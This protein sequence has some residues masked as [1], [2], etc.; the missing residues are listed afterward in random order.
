MDAKTIK[1]ELTERVN[2][3]IAYILSGGITRRELNS[4]EGD[5]EY[6]QEELYEHINDN[7][8]EV[9]DMNAEEWDS[10]LTAPWFRK[11]VTMQARCNALE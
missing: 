2:G 6:A 7:H 5:E 3:H 9:C 8:P 4:W 10:L 11:L 1:K